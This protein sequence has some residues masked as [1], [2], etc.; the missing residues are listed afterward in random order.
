MKAPKPP[1]DVK[2]QG[3][4]WS[5]DPEI[6]DQCPELSPAEKLE[7]GYWVHHN[8]RGYGII[9]DA[10]AEA[11]RRLVQPINDTIAT[12]DLPSPY[13]GRIGLQLIL[14]AMHQRGTSFWAWSSADWI[15]TIGK[16]HE[17]FQQRFDKPQGRQHLLAFAY[18]LREFMDF[19]E[20]P[21]EKSGLATKVFGKARVNAEIERVLTIMGEQGYGV[22]GDQRY[23]YRAVIS[24]AMLSN[25]SPYLA[26]LTEES[27][28][29]ARKQIKRNKHQ[30]G[31]MALSVALERLGILDRPIQ[32]LNQENRTPGSKGAMEGVDPEWADLCLRW[33]NTSTL[34]TTTR[35][36]Y[37]Y[38]LLLAGRWLAQKHPEVTHPNQWT[39]SLAAEYVGAVNR[40]VVGEYSKPSRHQIIG[41][42][43]SART[44]SGCLAAMRTFFFDCRE[45]EWIEEKFNAQSAFATPKPVKALIQPSPKQIDDTVWAKLLAAGLSFNSDDLDSPNTCGERPHW[46]PAEMIRALAVVWLFC[47]LRKDDI[48]SL[49]VG[50]IRWIEPDQVKPDGDETP[51][52]DLEGRICLLDIPPG[53]NG[54]PHT[55]AVDAIVG[56]AIQ[57]W[58]TI[59]PEQSLFTDRRTSEQ[60]HYL[61]AYRSQRLG[62]PY[63]NKSLIPFLC[64]QA[65]VPEQDI[66]GKITSHRGRHTILTQLSQFMT[67]PQL[68]SWSG[69]KS[70]DALMHYLQTT[71]LKQ[72]EAYQKSDYFK[73]NQRTFEVLIDRE[74]ITTGTAAQGEPWQYHKLSEQGYC[75]YDFFDHCPH[76]MACPQCRFYRPN[77]VVLQK[78]QQNK[79]N[80][81]KMLIEIELTDDE[82]AAVEEGVQAFDLLCEKLADVQTPEGP[83][84]RQLRS[85]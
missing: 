41:Q 18:V 58:E 53:K 16:S 78:L 13:S 52:P 67:I 11:L 77:S 34:T 5:L 76:K 30:H 63:L 14:L 56:K 85:V 61:F 75:V 57:A 50:C 43:F 33:F 82:R 35:D 7:L 15:D 73:R 42:P 26:D 79:A 49:R 64:N 19:W 70:T 31:F 48:R 81:Q 84:P 21:F 55:K 83:T 69:H 68:Q 2:K 39:R 29:I 8:G 74:A 6:Y 45:W 72:A 47:G 23:Q 71:L 60:V 24:A 27:L 3:W 17:E 38:S 4:S 44:K 80:L 46:Y 12:L 1:T 40:M 37:F 22:Q 62:D 51:T 54:R 28:D 36:G 66:H 20:L 32:R 59:R 65:G 25:R 9:S 10:T